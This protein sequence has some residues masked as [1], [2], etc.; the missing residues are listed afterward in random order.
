[1]EWMLMCEVM[2]VDLE[3]DTI[4]WWWTC[5]FYI[6]RIV[7]W[8]G[9]SILQSFGKVHGWCFGS[10]GEASEDIHATARKR[11]PIM[12]P[13]PYRNLFDI[14]GP[15]LNFRVPI[16]SV[17]AKFTQRLSIQSSYTQ[18]WVNLIC[19]WWVDYC[20]IIVCCQGMHHM[21]TAAFWFLPPL[22][23]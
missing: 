3:T 5:W 2:G 15:Y 7:Q 16:F 17:L 8:L 22:T 20:T 14:L 12:G 1:M 18:Q 23:R 10:W 9:R 13:G 6:E 19:L 21:L 11:V 4:Q